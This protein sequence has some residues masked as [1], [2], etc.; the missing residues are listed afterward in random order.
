MRVLHSS[1]G[2]LH[3]HS[4]VLREGNC[5]VQVGLVQLY[6]LV[7]SLERDHEDRLR[8]V[9]IEYGDEMKNYKRVAQTLGWSKKTRTRRRDIKNDGRPPD[10]TDALLGSPKK[11]L[12]R[13]KGAL[14]IN[15]NPLTTYQGYSAS[16]VPGRKYR[17]WLNAM[18]E[19]LYAIHTPLW[20][21]RSKGKSTHIFAKLM[22]HFSSQ[23]TWEMFQKGNIKT[24]LTLGQNTLH[25]AIEAQFPQSFLPDTYSSADL[26]FDG[27]FNSDSIPRAPAPPGM[28]RSLFRLHHRR[29]LVCPNNSSHRISDET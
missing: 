16:N 22:K 21:S 10:T 18:T 25:A 12:G 20:Y 11:K 8:G 27:L 24:I 9:S 14:N 19:C 17:C 4:S 6:A 3:A 5:T 28:A 13:P 29:K 26:Y 1:A 15:R 23:T 7:M 2:S